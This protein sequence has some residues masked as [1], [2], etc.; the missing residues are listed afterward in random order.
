MTMRHTGPTGPAPEPGA[1]SG[2]TSGTPGDA[3]PGPARTSAAYGRSATSEWAG[4]SERPGASELP[5]RSGASEW[6]AGA[7]PG[8][9]S[10]EPFNV[11]LEF[12]AFCELHRPRYLSYARVWIPDPDDAAAAVQLAFGQLAVRWRELLGSSN[13]TA[14]AWYILRSIV[15]DR[16]LSEPE[17]PQAR[18]ATPADEDLAILHYVVGLAA[19]EIA[20]VVGTDTANVAG[21]LRRSMLQDPGGW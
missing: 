17:V 16:L 11:P 15:A 13:P 4:A 3:T 12:A 9:A 1:A 14:H 2:P 8:A 6:A 10:G 5:E 20:D 19:P 18:V 7:G 21:R